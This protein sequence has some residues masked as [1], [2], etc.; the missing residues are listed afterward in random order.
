MKKLAVIWAD[1]SFARKISVLPALACLGFLLLL[2]VSWTTGARNAELLTT[3]EKGHYSSLEM[4]H[5]LQARLT[6]I[7]RAFQDAATTADLELLVEAQEMKAAMDV[8]ISEGRHIPTVVVEQLDSF[9]STLDNYFV[10]AESATQR[11]IAG[12]VT[13]SVIADLQAMNQDFN[14]M[15]ADL[16]AAIDADGLALKDS[17]VDVKREQSSATRTIFALITIFALV[18]LAISVFII[19]KTTR[20]IDTVVDCLKALSHGDLGDNDFEPTADEI[21]QMLKRVSQVTMIIRSLTLQVGELIESVRNGDLKHRGDPAKL[22]GAYGELVCNINELIDQLVEPIGLTSEYVEKIANGNIP[23]EITD[24]YNGDFNHIK[25]NINILIRTMNGLVSQTGMLTE[26]AQ[27]GQLDTR[28]DADQFFGAWNE[29]IV[30]INE[31]LDSV[32]GPIQEVSL[33]MSEMAKGSLTYEVSDTF[34]GEFAKLG[35]D[36]N[37]TG[38]KLNGIIGSIR[39]AAS[40]IELGVD[41][42]ASGNANLA[43]RTESQAARL[44]EA[45]ANITLMTDAVRANATS[46]SEA[47]DVAESTRS[48]AQEGESVVRQAADAM[49]DLSDSSQNI[50]AIIDVIDTI[51]FQTN[52]L[53]LNAA[54]E[55]ARAGEQ[56]KGFAVVASEVRQLAER[57]AEAAK[58]IKELI[59]DSTNKIQEGNRLVGNS[60]KTLEEIIASVKRVA[61]LVVS[62][63]DASQEQSQGIQD[64]NAIVVELDQMTT[65]NSE[66]VVEIASTSKSIGVQTES[67]TQML[68][69]FDA[70]N[71]AEPVAEQRRADEAPK[72]LAAS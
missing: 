26:A 40:A 67:L 59:G 62:I 31:T 68:R 71:A 12:E 5:A 21:G 30:G 23:P 65:Q 38:T 66:L 11:F 55:A 72:V 22:S 15:Q 35:D 53:A 7:H 61:D 52:L 42:V 16:S 20:A 34:E 1:L 6:K 54:V 2:W 70:G 47:R 25:E 57:S 27:S 49:S 33:F 37:A 4:R 29:L 14:A 63:S 56:G 45:R 60:G 8:S 41:E 28:G 64:V 48:L 18:M 50:V 32:T 44:E 39:S 58:E 13:D 36:A 9:A 10:L 24:D 46:A 69:F 19:R 3:V 43:S 17:F 51:A